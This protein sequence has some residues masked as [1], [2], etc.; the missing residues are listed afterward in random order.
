MDLIGGGGGAGGTAWL[1]ACAALA[2]VWV[3]AASWRAGDRPGAVA[4]RGLLG[5]LAALG[6][7]SV[8]YGLLELAGLDVR[9]EWVGRGT[10][11]A[12]GFAAAVGVVE[13]GAK[14]LGLVLAT[15]PGA[16]RRGVL[17]TALSVA[18][19]FAVAEAASVLAAAPWP[20]ALTRLT[21]A[22]VAHALL[23]APFAM[24][25]AEARALPLGQRSLRLAV[26]AAASAALHGLG[27]LGLAR[28]GWGQA[29]YA[30]ALLA[31]TVWIFA[32]ARAQGLRPGS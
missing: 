27:N 7:A 26:A 12:L 18:A 16:G 1:A 29:V 4:L 9:W 14:L 32:R 28:P 11:P 30:A 19:V 25:L 31:P 3:A 23:S 17:A 24:V 10:L 13:E 20:L 5:G 2:A 21:L 22:P 15:P 8:G 6:S